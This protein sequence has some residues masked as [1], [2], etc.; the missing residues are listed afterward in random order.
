[1]YVV[2]MYRTRSITELETDLV[3]IE[4]RIAQL[5]SEQ[6]VVVNEL[7]RA[8]ARQSDGSR[9]LVEWVQT[10]LDVKA[11]T[12]RD[13]V[14]ASRRFGW[15]RG[16][17]D[18]MLRGDATFDRTVATVKLSDAGATG[19][20]VGESYGRDLAGVARMIARRRHVTSRDEQRSFDSR[21]FAIQPNLDESAYRLWG[22]LPGVAGRTVEKAISDRADELHRIGGNLST[23]RGQRQ[24]DALT[25]MAHDS[26]D[27]TTAD[28]SDAGHVTV[29]VDARVED[30]LGTTA[31]IEYG[32]RVGPD[33]VEAL[34]CGGCVQVIGLDNHGIPVATS[35]AT[36]TIPPAIRHQVTHRDGGC[37]IDGCHSR[38]RLQPH[39]ITR[40]TDGGTHH[41]DNLATVCWYHHHIAIHGNGYQID[42]GSPPLRRRLIRGRP[43]NGDPPGTSP[44][45]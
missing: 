25:A 35:P 2:G 3:A 24:A 41:P 23:S 16:I 29:F 14:F 22:E 27:G 31:V 30:P 4:A 43:P 44:N 42:P 10:H 18:R 1:M 9:S 28:G 26:L 15:H 7:D 37:V 6:V 12:A 19:G 38:Y 21:F 39:H 11:D 33:T 8:Q 20:E 32:P 40:F 45:H 13:L 34:L 17:H 5:R 36:R